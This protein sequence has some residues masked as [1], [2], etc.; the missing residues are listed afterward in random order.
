M[1]FQTTEKGALSS[2]FVSISQLSN[3]AVK[4]D[5]GAVIGKYFTY[6]FFLLIVVRL[7][8]DGIEIVYSNGIDGFVKICL[9][10]RNLTGSSQE[11]SVNFPVYDFAQSDDDYAQ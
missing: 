4:N 11:D 1:Q 7:I 6:N 8:G 5:N 3:F 9:T 2:H 10:S